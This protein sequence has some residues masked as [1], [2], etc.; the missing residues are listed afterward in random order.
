MT[1]T[2][3]RRSHTEKERSQSMRKPFWLAFGILVIVM[4][5]TGLAAR[6]AFQDR[7]DDAREDDDRDSRSAYAIGLWGDLPYSTVQASVGV[8]NVIADMNKQ[9]LAFTAFDGDLKA[10][11]GSPCDDAL[12]TQALGYFNSLRAPAAL[13]PGDNDWSDCDRASSRRRIRAGT[14]LTVLGRRCVIRKASSKPTASQTASWNSLLR[15]ATRRSP[16]AARSPREVK[17]EQEGQLTRHFFYHD[18][19]RVER[20]LALFRLEVSDLTRR[21]WQETES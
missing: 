18:W 17:L 4:V 10:G 2:K 5:T 14:S 7:D 8:P 11:S 16:T 19:H 3:H 21:G 20:M 6:G 9:D 1:S 13:T 15:C 12:Y